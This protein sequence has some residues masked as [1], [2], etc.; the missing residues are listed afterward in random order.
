MKKVS[1]ILLS[2]LLIASMFISCDNSTKMKDELVQVTLSA[3][4]YRSLVV[5]SE[6]ETLDSVNW[7]YKATK[8]SETQFDFGAKSEETSIIL[9]PGQGEEKQIL[10]LS[11]GKWDFELFGRNDDGTLL[12]YGIVEDALIIKSTAPTSVVIGVS[13]YTTAPGTLVLDN[14]TIKLATANG[15]TT[16]VAPNYLKVNNTEYFGFTGSKE[17]SGLSA[18]Q[19][20]VTV[21]WKQTVEEDNPNTKAIETSY[22]VVVASETVVVTVYGGRTTTITGSVSEETGSGIINGEV[23]IKTK[24]TVSKTVV[25]GEPTIFTVNVAPVNS[26]ISDEVKNTTVYFPAGVIEDGSDVRLTVGVKDFDSGYIV[27]D[28]EAPITGLSLTIEGTENGSI[29]NPFDDSVC[30]TTYVLKNLDGVKVRY[31]NPSG[32][33]EEYS[34][35]V[36]DIEP[37]EIEI[38]DNFEG[39]YFKDTGKLVFKTKHFSEYY[40]VANEFAL[41]NETTN[42]VYDDIVKA[43]EG[44]TSHQVIK[45]VSDLDLSEVYEAGS[46]TVLNFEDGITFDLNSKKLTSNNFSIVFQGDNLCIKNGEFIV[47]NNGA[48]ALFVGDERTTQGCVIDNIICDGGINIYNTEVT[49]DNTEVESGSF[50]S[51]WADENTSI[52][53]NSGTFT[54]RENVGVAVLGSGEF[55]HLIINGGEYR[56]DNFIY[57]ANGFFEF[58]FD[59]SSKLDS[60]KF[61]VYY[62]EETGYYELV[63]LIHTI[64]DFKVKNKLDSILGNSNFKSE[65]AIALSGRY[66][67]E[68]DITVE[69]L[70]YV[71]EG[72]YAVLDLNGHKIESIFKGFSIGNFGSLDIFD[73]SCTS[74]TIGTGIV[75]NSS[76]SS[77]NGNYSHDAI[78]NFGTLNIYGGTFGDDDLETG[79][80]NTKHLGAALRNLGNATIYGGSFT[81]ADNYQQYSSGANFYSYAIR[82]SGNLNIENCYVYGAMNGGISADAGVITIKGGLVDIYGS[83]SFYALVNNKNNNGKTII[84]DGT[85]KKT[86]GKGSL[87]GGFTGMPSWDATSSL[88]ENGFTVNGGTFIYNNQSVSMNQ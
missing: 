50:Y 27:E 32:D 25:A 75:Y 30:I 61:D 40:V 18:G 57:S 34:I 1:L 52:T 12:Y 45:L 87:L 8:V 4:D 7:F 81:C 21:A 43:V 58:S 28:N 70:I 55:G 59:P 72:V 13:P 33:D 60:T 74:E 63:N 69:D 24:G 54:Q 22:E 80:E 56:G 37:K 77:D 71:D 47:A 14:V 51:V 88:E 11:Q 73:S 17:I 38:E 20:T 10:T 26:I 2:V 64:S 79:N 3:G 62:N 82:S 9:F 83:E 85:F 35:N 76:N 41:I 67:L 16:D 46:C 29:T 39:V 78:R 36:L 49:I 48:Y 65:K 6:I 44:A 31:S 86:G 66:R 19:Y 42:V 5:S 15:T 53:I 68:A 84:Y 23:E